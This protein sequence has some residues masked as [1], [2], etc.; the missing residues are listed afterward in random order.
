MSLKDTKIL[1]PEIPG[2]WTER[3]LQWQHQRLERC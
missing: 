1:I 2:D 3:Q